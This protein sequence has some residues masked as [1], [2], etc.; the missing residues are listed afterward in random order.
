MGDLVA[1]LLLTYQRTEY[2]LATIASI[3][4]HLKYPRLAFYVADDGSS[5]EHFSAVL[6]A[7]TDQ[8]I[9]GHHHQRLGPGASWNLG[10]SW[11]HEATDVLLYVG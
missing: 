11:C 4:E 3:L 5:D 8:E 10:V 6:A 9:I 1:V 7:L 2:A